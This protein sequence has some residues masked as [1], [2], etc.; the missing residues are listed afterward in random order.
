MRMG[1]I[2]AKLL[3]LLL[4]CGMLAVA[5]AGCGSD[6]TEGENANNTE[7]TEQA[8]DKEYTHR[9][10]VMSD[11]HYMTNDSQA[12][13]NA[14][15][16]GETAAPS[17]GD[18]FGYTQTEKMS[19]VLEDVNKFAEREKVEGV[20]VLGD[21]G[22]DD[23]GFRNLSENYVQKFKDDVM[24][25]FPGVSYALPGNHDSYPNDM[26]K[27]T[28]GYDRQYSVKIGDAAFIMLDTYAD[29]STVDGSGSGYTGIDVDWLEKELEKYPTEKIFL[30]MHYLKNTEANYKLNKI[31]SENERIVC[32]FRGHT[33]LNEVLICDDLND[34]FL[35]DLGGYA[36]MGQK[37]AAGYDYSVYDNSWA[38][39]FG[40]LEW[41][42]TEAHYY[43]VK[44]DRTYT[45]S[46]GTFN[47]AGAIE[48][49]I[50]IKIGE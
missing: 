41:N 7:A 9:I 3:A 19:A 12:A 43:H 24:A 16:P 39:G 2:S 13:Y 4:S 45:G 48:D 21:L 50:T 29:L 33:H 32:L 27:E 36:Y 10:I 11:P 18:A 46:N 30:C 44:F 28:F 15:H 38:W 26:W 22:T 47:F 40:V 5:L 6:V 35:I 37:T 20:L 34:E 42:D 1:R 49:E 8:G 25:K 14:S 31:L 17:A 23:Y